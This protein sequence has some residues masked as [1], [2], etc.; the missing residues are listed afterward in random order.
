MSYNLAVWEGERPKTNAEA[1]K[2]FEA[3]FAQHQEAEKSPKPTPAIRRYVKALLVKY[4]DLDDDNEDECPWSDS[5]LINNAAGPIFYFAM[6]FS[7]AKIAS[8]FAAKLA[9]EHGLVCFDPQSNK[10]R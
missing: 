9:K 7:Q 6:V 4:P 1:K 10:L 3:L 5:P 2:T 8:A